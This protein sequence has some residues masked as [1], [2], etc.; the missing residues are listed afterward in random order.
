MKPSALI[1]LAALLAAASGC[2]S[3]VR[4]HWRHY[5]ESVYAFTSESEDFDLAA[6]IGELE[7]QLGY[8]VERG[9]PV[10]PGFHAHLGYLYYLAGNAA[11]ARGHFETEK[12]KYPESAAFMNDLLRRMAG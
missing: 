3:K 11:Q 4:Y 9:R 12:A 8:S 2:Q 7:E 1:L 10:P 5:E 6:E